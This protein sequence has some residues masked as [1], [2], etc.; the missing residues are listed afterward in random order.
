MG[1][2]ERPGIL[3]GCKHTPLI[4]DE[5]EDEGGGDWE[6]G[7]LILSTKSSKGSMKAFEGKDRVELAVVG[8]LDGVKGV[9]VRCCRVGSIYQANQLS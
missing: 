7:S 3:S 2:I 1:W 4:V 8:G 5:D 6:A 9:C